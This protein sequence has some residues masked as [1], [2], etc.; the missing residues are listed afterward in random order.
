MRED[1]PWAMA[2]C[3]YC[4]ERM[5][6]SQLERHTNLVHA[7]VVEAEET[8]RQMTRREKRFFLVFGFSFLVMAMLVL[9]GWGLAIDDSRYY[10]GLV[11]A[12]FILIGIIFALQLF[13][14]KEN[15]ELRERARQTILNT[16]VRCDICE[17]M[18]PRK[19]YMKH[20]KSVHPKQVP[21]EW[22]R[23]AI[24]AFF[25]TVMVGGY[26]LVSLVAEAGLLSFELTAY[27]GIG[28]IVLTCVLGLWI[29]YLSQ[30]GEPRHISKMRESWQNER[31]DPDVRR[32]DPGK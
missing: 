27:L 20:L 25:L 3:E 6:H 17:L 22:F 2:T 19:D 30:V 5:H 11:S 15:K 16:P 7:Q 23:I 8:L 29:F 13:L 18:I 4:F 24:V 31:F 10:L 12:P 14:P 1:S 26:I 9:V 21:Y 28:W 32:N